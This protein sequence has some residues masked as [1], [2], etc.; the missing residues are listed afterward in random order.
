LFHTEANNKEENNKHGTQSSLKDPLYL[1]EKEFV[2]DKLPCV[3]GEGSP[4]E[5]SKIGMND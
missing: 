5:I 4:Y 3:E 1:E 2:G